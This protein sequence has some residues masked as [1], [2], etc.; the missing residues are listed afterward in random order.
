MED[1][2]YYVYILASHR[3]G[4]LYVGFTIG[5]IKRCWEHKNDIVKG[6][7]NK[8]QVHRLVHYEAFG[9]KEAAV[10]REKQLKRWNRK[11]KLELIEKANPDW[12]DLYDKINQ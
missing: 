8:Y 12:E 3:N 10:L 5:L 11:W 4:T 7:T 9:D 6:F 1:K 2:H